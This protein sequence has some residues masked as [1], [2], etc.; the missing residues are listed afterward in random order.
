MSSRRLVR[1]QFPVPP[2]TY[3]S[4]YM[5]EVVRAFSIFINQFQNPG[6]IRATEITLTALQENDVGLEPGAVFQ[7][8]G[9]LK[10]TLAYKPHPAGSVGTGGVGTVEVTTP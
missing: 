8:D 5:A 1:P 2:A 9:F 10:I 6:D 7:Q 4:S 3:N